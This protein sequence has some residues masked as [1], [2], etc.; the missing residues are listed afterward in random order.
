MLGK[1]RRALRHRIMG[2]VLA[3]AL[4]L[5][6]VT[7]PL[8]FNNGVYAAE[9][10]TE[11]VVNGS[12]SDVDEIGN[13]AI[14]WVAFTEGTSKATF[15]TGEVLFEIETMGADWSNYL[16]YAPGINLKNR[17]SYEIS[18]KVKS[19]VDRVVQ[20]EFD[21]GRIDIRKTAVKAGEETEV[22]YT[23]TST[24]D[25]NSNPYM[26]YLGNIDNEINPTEAHTVEI[27]DFSV[28]T[29]GETG[30]GTTEP[31]NPEPS[32]PNED[33]EDGEVVEAVEGNL[34]KNGNFED[35]AEGWQ[36]FSDLADIYW[37][38]YR[39]VFQI[40]DNAADW[41]QSLVQ[42]VELEAGTTY[43][44]RFDIESTVERTVAAG[45]DNGAKRDEFHS[46]V[47]PAN[48][49]TTLSY[50]TTN[51]I[52]GSNKFMIYLGT[53]VGAHKVVISNVSIVEA[54]V[55]LPDTK[56]DVAPEALKSIKGLAP[57]DAIALKDGNFTDG[58]NQWDHW[59]V[60]W[61]KQWDVVKY[62]PVENGMAVYIKNVGGGDGNNA[63]DV[64][65]NQQINLKKNLQYTLSFDVH[66]EKA[67]AI[68]VTLQELGTGEY[69][70]TIGLQKDE[71]RHVVLNIPVQSEDAVNKLFSI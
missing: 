17:Q 4:V 26:F 30:N 47:I 21:G 23:Y 34:L 59:E 48:T 33:R 37:N 22:R 68:N 44:V 67:R 69:S 10:Q 41:S 28:K 3:T 24:V 11:L 62:T 39:T 43:E 70:K 40:K 49:K 16:K 64:Q 46:Q 9:T 38:K 36:S 63:W 71:T 27:S 52:T 58:L 8:F 2:V 57:E 6:P 54:P 65:M 14:N 13:S 50:K 53:N 29:S 15:K 1:R 31:S 61:M 12:F 60:D 35:K 66:T 55:E 20:Y 7:S 19:S 25:Y 56:N 32:S 42:N 45:F 18:F 5:Q 51:A